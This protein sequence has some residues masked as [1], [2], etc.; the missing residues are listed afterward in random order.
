MTSVRASVHTRALSA[1]H[2]EAE[3]VLKAIYVA[4]HLALGNGSVLLSKPKFSM[5]K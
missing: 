2:V 1:T 4:L 5:V 3:K